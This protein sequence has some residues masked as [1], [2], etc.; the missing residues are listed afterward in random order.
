MAES[1]AADEAES[2]VLDPPSGQEGRARTNGHHHDAVSLNELSN[3]DESADDGQ[4]SDSGLEQANGS[5][6]PTGRQRHRQL[7]LP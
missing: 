4:E 5:S 6:V 3:G 1:E 2:P 7:P